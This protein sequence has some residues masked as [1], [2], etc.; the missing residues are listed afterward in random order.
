MPVEAPLSFGQLYSWREIDAYP[1]DCKHEAN[2]SATW[3]LRGFSLHRVL[4]VLR[5]LSD[6]HEPLRT[7]YEVPNG[8]PVQHVRDDLAMPVERLD[9][10]VPDA[11]D[12]ERT[13][14]ALIERP[15]AMTGDPCWRALLVTTGDE[16]MFCSLSFSHLILDVWSVLELTEQARALLAGVPAGEVA[17]RVGPSPRVLADRQ[18]D[19]T[20]AGRRASAQRYWRSILSEQVIDSLPAL[21]DGEQRPRIQATLHSHRLG[22]LAGQAA[23]SLGVTPPSVLLGVLAAA[24]SERTGVE[25]LPIGLMSSNRFAPELRHVVGTLNQLIPVLATV[26]Y[27]SSLSDHITRVHWA[28]AKAYR[29]SCYDIDAVGDLARQAST[30]RRAGQFNSLFRCW[31][32]HIQLDDKTPDAADETPAELEWNPMARQFG[33]PLDVRVTVRNGRTSIA[34]RA[35]SELLDERQLADTLRTVALGV[36]RAAMEPAANLKELWID[37]GT[38]VD[39]TLFPEESAS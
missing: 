29:Y 10:P 6:W 31:F 37:H 3:D 16:P 4:A 38:S 1:D 26:D 12:P 18:R 2:L 21:D 5:Q 24:L 15:F 36:Q 14:A 25:P 33:Q 39:P 11:G 35:D 27:V 19:E 30:D 22:V 34:L 20:S 9:R 17:V 7:T 23:K 8:V 28:G 13:T 32:N